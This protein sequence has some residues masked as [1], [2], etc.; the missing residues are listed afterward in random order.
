MKESFLGRKHLAFV[1]PLREP[2]TKFC[3]YSL[4][5]MSFCLTC[6]PIE[7]SLKAKAQLKYVHEEEAGTDIFVFKHKLRSVAVDWGW[8]LWCVSLLCQGGALLIR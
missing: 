5:D 8:R 6:A 2:G 3:L 7:F 1:I 4:M